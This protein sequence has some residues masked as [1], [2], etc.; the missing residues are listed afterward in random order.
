MK[1]LQAALRVAGLAG[2]LV[3]C[4]YVGRP[5]YWELEA[6]LSDLRE[7]IAAPRAA[8]GAVAINSARPAAM[9][10]TS[11]ADRAAAIDDL[12]IL[13]LRLVC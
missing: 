11:L 10:L 3:V 5:I 4:F 9:A 12:A 13:P 7:G 1:P 8:S 2:V 6:K